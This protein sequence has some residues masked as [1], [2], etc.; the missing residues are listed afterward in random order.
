VEQVATLRLMPNMS[1]WRPCDA[2]ESAIAWRYAIEHAD[3]PTCLLFS[4]QGLPHQERTQAQL[5]DAARGGYVLRDGGDACDA[6]VIATGSEIG[7]AVA[8]SEI[9]AGKGIAARVVSMPCTD[10]FDAQSPSYKESV[11]PASVKARVSVEAG[12]T[13]YWFKYIGDRGQA[14]GVDSFGLSA[15]F[16]E[17]YEH[18]GLTAQAVA[19]AV[20]ESMAAIASET[21]GEAAE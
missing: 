11:L 14:V 13:D 2:V 8:A 12:V 3:G 19:S 5:A 4:R 18:F 15:P 7:L 16:E 10:V 21:A 17:V 1:V 9:L 20:E 6:I